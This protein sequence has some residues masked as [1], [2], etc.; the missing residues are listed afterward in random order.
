[1]SER[2]CQFFATALPCQQEHNLTFCCRF[3]KGMIDHFNKN[4][5]L[6][7]LLTIGGS[8]DKSGQISRMNFVIARKS[9]PL[10]K[11]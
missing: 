2:S 5:V 1:M 11:D 6:Q 4:A 7:R 9:S 10:G 8:N 3:L